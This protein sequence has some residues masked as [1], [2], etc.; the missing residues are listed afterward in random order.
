MGYRV[1]QMH[2]AGP[3]NDATKGHDKDMTDYNL[4]GAEY[5]MGFCGVLS[6]FICAMVK[7]CYIGDGK[8]PTF[9]DGILIMG[10]QTPTIGLM[11]LSPIIWK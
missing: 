6:F 4:I 9:N 5:P 10:I 2:G 1:L 3:A 7:S 11:S 8:N